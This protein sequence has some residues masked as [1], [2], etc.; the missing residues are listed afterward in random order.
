MAD[1]FSVHIAGIIQQTRNGLEC[2]DI[3]YMTLAEANTVAAFRTVVVLAISSQ[4]ETIY[5]YIDLASLVNKYDIS[6]TTWDDIIIIYNQHHNDKT[7]SDVFIYTDVPKQQLYKINDHIFAVTTP[8]VSNMKDRIKCYSLDHY[9]YVTGSYLNKKAPYI[10]NI[11]SRIRVMPDLVFTKTGKEDVNFEN[12]LVSVDG[13]LGFPEYDPTTDELYI[14]NGAYFLR[15]TS[16]PDQNIVFMDFSDM[17]KP[18]TKIINKYFHECAPELIIGDK[19]NIELYHNETG[20]LGTLFSRQIGW[21]KQATAA[22]R[23]TVPLTNIDIDNTIEY[24]P[25]VCFGGRL[26]LPGIDNVDYNQYIYNKN[27]VAT[28]H[29]KVTLK[30]DLNLLSAVVASNLKHAGIFMGNSSF[31]HASI[32]YVLSNIFTANVANIP[33]S[34][35]EWRAIAYLCKA[36]IPFVTLLP[37]NR[38]FAFSKINPS[39]TLHD[40]EFIFPFNSRGILFSEQTKEIMDYNVKDYTKTTV[41]ETEPR[42]ALYLSQ[43]GQ[44]ASHLNNTQTTTIQ[45][46]GRADIKE[47]FPPTAEFKYS[48]L[49][50]YC[51]I[52]ENADG[53][54]IAKSN[55]V[56]DSVPY[57]SASLIWTIFQTQLEIPDSLR[58]TDI[59]SEQNQKLVVDGVNIEDVGINIYDWKKHYLIDI[60]YAGKKSTLANSIS[61]ID[62]PNQNPDTPIVHTIEYE[63]IIDPIRKKGTNS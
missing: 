22:I 62:D 21:W 12:T 39:M 58:Y 43:R 44:S 61:V 10:R 29:V 47:F 35:D 31:Y 19:D 49:N 8:F 50:G 38:A 60:I 3:S 17:I 14:K 32:S 24:V 51:Y 56:T 45:I 53:V 55:S 54:I 27:N 57:T 42:K 41:I 6:P 36:D 20:A 52:V 18:G 2:F 13:N 5:Q 11:K 37:M 4:T 59:V 63:R 28:T 26:F 33:M 30:L 23:F 15:G 40:G 1:S 7:W 9:D 34:T 25:L 48:Q 16:G 46:Q